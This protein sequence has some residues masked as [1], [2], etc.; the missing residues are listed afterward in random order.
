MNSELDLPLFGS[1]IHVRN[2]ELQDHEALQTLCATW[3]DKV[4]LEGSAFEPDYIYKCLTQADLPPIPDASADHYRMKVIINQATSLPVGF[5]DL[6]EG[7]PNQDT[8][9]IGMFLLAK[10]AQGQGF[11]HETIALITQAATASNFKF[12]SLAVYLK[13]WTGLRFWQNNGFSK[14]KGLYGDRTY[15][16][17]NF[18]LMALEKSL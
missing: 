10:E 18:A 1:K 16:T 4:L 7:Y 15:S 13:N 9:W 11:G 8:L 2:A 5:M 14:I 6:Y 3:T 17:E 12:I